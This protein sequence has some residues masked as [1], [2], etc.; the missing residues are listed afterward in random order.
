MNI[1]SSQDGQTALHQAS[2][3]GNTDL[4][5]LLVDFGAQLDNK[6]KVSTY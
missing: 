2:S 5:K 4:V 6:D 3:S 1:V